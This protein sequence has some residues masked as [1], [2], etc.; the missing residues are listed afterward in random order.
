MTEW[1]KPVLGYELLYEASSYG[2]IR[3]VDH[4]TISTVGVARRFKGKIL[5]PS[6]DKDGYLTVALHKNGIQK[7]HRVHHLVLG[8]FKGPRPDGLEGCH[9]NGNNQDNRIANLRWGTISSNRIDTINHGHHAGVNKT[10]CINGHDYNES[11]TYVDP[12][13]HRRCRACA[14]DY[15]AARRAARRKS[16]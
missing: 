1:W 8:A 6:P 12:R 9:N 16:A 2:E 4:V 10:V 14:R 3:S 7:T 5:K 15:D 13:N 11:N